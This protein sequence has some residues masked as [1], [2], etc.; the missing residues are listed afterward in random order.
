MSEMLTNKET[1]LKVD[2][3]I[4]TNEFIEKKLWYKI[5]QWQMLTDREKMSLVGTSLENE[6]KVL[7]NKYCSTKIN[8]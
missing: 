1:T 6:I 8:Y 2:Q 5:E 7:K 3:Q 4:Q